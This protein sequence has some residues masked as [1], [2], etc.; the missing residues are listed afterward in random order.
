[1]EVDFQTAYWWQYRRQGLRYAGRRAMKDNYRE[2]LEEQLALDYD[3]S[4]SEV[5]SEENIFRKMV[6]KQG[7]RPAADEDCMLKIAVYREKLLVMADERILDW[8]RKFF[9]DRKG[10]WLSEPMNLIT[11]HQKLREYGQNL[12][13]AHHYYIPAK[14]QT[15]TP[16]RF[17]VKWYE[18]E[19]IEV[20]RDDDRFD[21]AL[22]FDEKIPDMLA[23]CAVEGETILGM[24]GATRDA[25]KMWQIGVNV[26][27]EGRG[28]GVGTY[29]TTLLKERLL[30][31]GIVPF[32]STVESHIKSQRVAFEAGFE[33]IFY[34]IFSEAE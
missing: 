8:C 12:A 27:P 20:F 25:E 18:Q 3:C 17:D 13:D 33:P 26:T 30:E 22:L 19:E 9:A 31:R 7:A 28:K 2:I 5:Q 14:M 21:E 34:E 4:I 10:T 23:V 1:M 15:V 6:Q 29:V 11:I 32:Y 24:A 16:K